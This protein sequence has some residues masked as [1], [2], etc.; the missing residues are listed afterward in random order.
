[1][2]T[3]VVGAPG[4]G[5]ADRT[6]IIMLLNMFR[7]FPLFNYCIGPL[8]RNGWSSSLNVQLT[9]F[10]HKGTAH[11]RMVRALIWWWQRTSDHCHR[12]RREK[13]VVGRYR[14]LHI[15]CS[16]L[17]QLKRPSERFQTIHLFIRYS[18]FVISKKLIRRWNIGL[19]MKSFYSFGTGCFISC[20]GSNTYTIWT[21]GMRKRIISCSS[22]VERYSWLTIY[23]F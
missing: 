12:T 15:C 17:S 8:S 5:S 4:G 13:V 1:M 10:V 9:L 20:F 23:R 14:D 22:L 18:I 6:R 16:F 7:Y 2:L 3:R 11:W 19:M 21:F